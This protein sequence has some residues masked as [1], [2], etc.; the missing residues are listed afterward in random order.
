MWWPE[1]LKKIALRK[2]EGQKIEGVKDSTCLHL[3]EI[4]LK[5]GH[6]QFETIVYTETEILETMSG[7]H[8]LDL[9]AVLK[10]IPGIGNIRNVC[11]DMCAAFAD[12]VRQA[13]PAAEIVLDRFHIMKLLNK[14][15]DKLRM[16][17]YKKLEQEGQ[18]RFKSI[19]FL[20]FK[21]RGILLSWEKR[22]V[23]NYL[24]R[25]PE[26]KEIYW[27]IQAFRRI[28][29]SKKPLTQIEASQQLTDWCS[30]ARKYLGKFVKT[31]ESWWT[32]VLNACLS[33]LSNGRAEG[34][35]N[36]IKLIKRMGYGF[37]NRLNFKR[38]IQAA[39]NP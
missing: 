32:E 34:I 31:I 38:R 15:L 17:L 11:M 26:M 28:L 23:K 12:A 30:K 1:F 19:R 7:K 27:L 6:G 22:L 37:R 24:Q 16:K 9:Q 39:C 8:S 36:K 3:D 21:S 14:K 5:K 35:N 4:A 10:A 2:E 33:P 13:M 29:F 20:L 25:C 18:E